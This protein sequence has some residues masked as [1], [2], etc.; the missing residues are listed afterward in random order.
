MTPDDTQLLLVTPLR[1]KAPYR[2]PKIFI[3]D[4]LRGRAFWIEGHATVL[5]VLHI[6]RFAGVELS[7]PGAVQ[8]AT[9]AKTVTLDA[10]LITLNDLEAVAHCW[11]RQHGARDVLTSRRIPRPSR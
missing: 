9:P 4:L 2:D 7:R 5:Q 1:L 10:W 3:L 11:H 8:V 6:H